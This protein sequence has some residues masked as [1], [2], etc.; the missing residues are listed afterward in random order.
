MKKI[1]LSAWI[2]LYTCGL[3]AQSIHPERNG[4]KSTDK[5]YYAFTQAT[6]HTNSSKVVKNATLLIH[7]GKVI[8]SGKNVSLPINTVVY[9]LKGKHIYPSFIDLFSTYG[10]KQSK[11]KKEKHSKRPQFTSLKKGPYHWNQ[12]VTPEVET[13]NMLTHDEKMGSKL[14]K[15]GFGTVLSHHHD[16][17]ISGSGVL[18]CLGK[19]DNT[20]TDVADIGENILDPKASLHLSF[21]KG[22][23]TQ[24]YPSSDGKHRVDTPNLLRRFLV[25]EKQA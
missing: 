22:S 1:W 5:N 17:I 20:S 10:V 24:N 13:F 21:D 7:K 6:L 16:G 4:V 19:K 23:S 14:R 11:K 3:Y 18:L 2:V 12:A 15:M 9:D 25:Q 8:A